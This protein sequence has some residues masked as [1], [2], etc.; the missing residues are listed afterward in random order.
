LVFNFKY[1]AENQLGPWE[2]LDLPLNFG[3]DRANWPFIDISN[4]EFVN[5]NH[6]KALKHISI[7]EDSY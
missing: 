1:E 7:T 3:P 2:E 4:S 5:L 6:G